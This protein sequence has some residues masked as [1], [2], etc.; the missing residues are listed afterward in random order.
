[1]CKISPPDE[2]SVSGSQEAAPQE[3]YEAGCI[4]SLLISAITTMVRWPCW[5]HPAGGGEGGGQR[6]VAL[7]KLPC[8]DMCWW[9]ASTKKPSCH[10]SSSC[11]RIR[12]LT[13]PDFFLKIP[14]LGSG[15]DSWNF[16]TLSLIPG[17]PS[18]L[19]NND[20]E[21]ERIE[22]EEQIVIFSLYDRTITSAPFAPFRLGDLNSCSRTYNWGIFL[23]LYLCFYM[24]FCW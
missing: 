11:R 19:V 8:S 23:V 13:I 20:H 3:P 4:S 7:R 1:M 2:A 5:W 21:E 6:R 22:E 9:G 16:F 18:L 15:E 14:H 12:A 10:V 24:F 17:S